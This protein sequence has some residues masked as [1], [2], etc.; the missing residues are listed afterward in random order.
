VKFPKGI[1]ALNNQ[2]GVHDLTVEAAL[3]GSVT[4]R[5]KL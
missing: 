1:V 5:C 2:V 4:L 3:T